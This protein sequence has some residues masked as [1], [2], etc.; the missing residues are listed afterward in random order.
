MRKFLSTAIAAVTAAGAVVA[1]A[2]PADAR[3]YYRQGGYYHHHHGSNDAAVAVAAGIAGLAIG[4]ALSSDG[5]H[6]G[7][8]GYSSSYGYSNGYSYDP[9]YDSYSGDYYD[10]GGYYA[11][12]DRVCITRE[13][14]WDPYIGRHVTVE[15]RYPC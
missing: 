9:R 8:S 4:A 15:R 14:V 13:R 3:G 11:P 5:N 6:R 7:R 1:T 12:R 10:R 2:L